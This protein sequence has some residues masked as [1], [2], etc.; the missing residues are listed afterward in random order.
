VH[1]GGLSGCT[2]SEGVSWGKFVSPHEGGRYAEVSADA[3]AVLPLLV[4]ALFEELGDRQSP[5][6]GV[7]SHE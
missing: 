4:K 3:T 1:W 6:S 5:A 2:Y 7:R